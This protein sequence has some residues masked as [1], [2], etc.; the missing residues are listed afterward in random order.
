MQRSPVDL[1]STRA[2]R[3]VIM[4]IVSYALP[5]HATP[6]SDGAALVCRSWPPP[7]PRYATSGLLKTRSHLSLHSRLSLASL[8]HAPTV[9]ECTR[10]MVSHPS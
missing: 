9:S 2:K 1:W 5:Q 6:F 3:A 10:A 8:V 4:R 7:W